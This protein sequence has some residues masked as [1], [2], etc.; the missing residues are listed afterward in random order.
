MGLCN[1]P[2]ITA[3][4]IGVNSESRGIEGPRD[5]ADVYRQLAAGW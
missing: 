1:R 3:S 2:V 5:N 4:L